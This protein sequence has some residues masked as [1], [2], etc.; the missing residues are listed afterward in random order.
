MVEERLYS[1]FLRFVPKQNEA[2]FFC[3]FFLFLYIKLIVQKGVNFEIGI[4]FSGF[5][6][7]NEESVQLKPHCV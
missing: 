6:A 5:K 2:S 3:L 4:A 7:K 1:F